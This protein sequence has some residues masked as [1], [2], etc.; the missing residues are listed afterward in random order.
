MTSIELQD[1]KWLL[2]GN[3]TFKLEL[4]DNKGNLIETPFNPS[5]RTVV[6]E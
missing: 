3:I 2:K 6:L 1:K 5:I 4:I